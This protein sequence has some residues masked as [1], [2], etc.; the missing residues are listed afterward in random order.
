MPLHYTHALDEDTL[1]IT[2]GPL[3]RVD[4]Q[5]IAMIDDAKAKLANTG[6]SVRDKALFHGFSASAKFALRFTI[7]HPELVAAV[8]AGGVNGMPTIPASEWEGRQLPYPVGI[9][10]LEAITGSPLDLIAYREVP[11]FIYMGATDT[12]DTLPYRDAVSPEHAVL[13]KEILG[14]QMMPTRWL[15]SQAIFKTLHVKAQ[16]VTYNQTPH[17][18]RTEMLKD[19]GKFFNANAGGSFSPIEPF[20]YPESER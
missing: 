4:L 19:L 20:Q 16:M 10:D 7:L 5:L 1:K 11:Q 3:K 15:K 8:A 9:A 14:E 2:S 18:I 12:A 13:I 17:T 6:I